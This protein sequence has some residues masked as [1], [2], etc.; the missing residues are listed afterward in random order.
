MTGYFFVWPIGQPSRQSFLGK[1]FGLSRVVIQDATQVQVQP[2]SNILRAQG[3]IIE[4]LNPAQAQK[5]SEVLRE[6]LQKRTMGNAN[7]L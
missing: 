2:R 7:G 6:V 3:V 4:G 5:I 1:I